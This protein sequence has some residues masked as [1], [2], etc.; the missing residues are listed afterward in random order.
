MYKR[1]MYIDGGLH[2]ALRSCAHRWWRAADF[3]SCPP[4]AEP[5]PVPSLL[6]SPPGGSQPPTAWPSSNALRTD[7][8]RE[9]GTQKAT[10]TC[11]ILMFSS[12]SCLAVCFTVCCSILQ[13]SL[14]KEDFFLKLQCKWVNTE[15]TVT[16]L[17]VRCQ[18]V[19]FVWWFLPVMATCE[20][21]IALGHQQ[22]DQPNRPWR[23]GEQNHSQWC[24]FNEHLVPRVG[25][26]Y[27][28]DPG[29]LVS[30]GANRTNDI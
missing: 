16:V 25:T 18:R 1:L 9:R 29:C 15:E 11:G 13:V 26:I 3:P 28:I 23:W 7:L 20:A 27:I 4:R 10:S 8:R 14:V 12:V 19:D 30:I 5:L 24:R 6:S 2:A 17:S 22:T 21:P